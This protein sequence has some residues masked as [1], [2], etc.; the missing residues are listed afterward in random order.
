MGI[1]LMWVWKGSSIGH[2]LYSSESGQTKK[3]RNLSWQTGNLALVD[4]LCSCFWSSTLLKRKIVALET[5][6]ILRT[7]NLLNLNT[8][9]E[10][11][12]IILVLGENDFFLQVFFY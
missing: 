4:A 11:P 5:K 10:L 3:V 8:K 7:L 12:L 6:F 2:F 1:D 9:N